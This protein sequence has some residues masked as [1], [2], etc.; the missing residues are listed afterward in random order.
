HLHLT[1]FPTRR[2]SDLPLKPKDGLSG[3]PAIA[4]VAR[5]LAIF[6]VRAILPAFPPVVRPLKSIVGGTSSNERLDRT[7][8]KPPRMDTDEG[9]SEEHT[10]E[11]Q[12]RFDL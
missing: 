12:S 4:R 7:C 5:S 9:R 3:P 8:S 11:L 6:S 10:S 2:S 1:P